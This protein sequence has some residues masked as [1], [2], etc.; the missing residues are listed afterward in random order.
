[1][2]KGG[3]WA[4]SKTWFPELTQVHIPNGMSIGSVVIAQLT[5]NINRHNYTVERGPVV[6]FCG[7][8]HYC[9]RPYYPTAK[10]QS[11]SSYMDSAEPFPDR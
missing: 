1:M 7:Q 8:P 4:L 3:I 5:L 6:G 9:Y 2:D 10:F 11:L